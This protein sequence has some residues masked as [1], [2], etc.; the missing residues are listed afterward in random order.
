MS[1]QAPARRSRSASLPS[2]GPAPQESAGVPPGGS[3]REA[4]PA[5][6]AIGAV[7]VIAFVWVM[8]TGSYD[9]Y[10]AALVAGVLV[11][12]TIP[13]ARHA[14]KVERWPRL[15]KLVMAAMVFRI[16]GSLAR[17]FVA[18]G[19]YGGVADASTYTQVA[20][21]H[22]EAFR[23]FHLFAPTTGVFDGFVPWLDTVI[24]V[25][26]G[27]TELGA[28]FV[29]SWLNFLG[30]YLFYRAFRVGYP[31][32]DHRRYAALVLF[33]PS[34]IYWPS[35]LGKEGWMVFVIGLGCYGLARALAG[36]RF[37]Y[38]GLVAGI[39]GMLLVRPHLALIFLPAAILAFVLRRARPGR[40]RRPI[41]TVIGVVVLVV[42]LL[43]VIS[44][45]Q[46][47]FGITNLDV[48]TVT[49]QLQT[50]RVQTD[51]GNSAFNPP[52]AQ[53]PLG[54]PEAVATVLFRPFPFE[55]HGL[56]VLVA[57][58]EG[59]VLI[60]LTVL[61][62]R[63][64]AGMLRALRRNPYVLFCALYSLL[65]IFAFSNFSNFGILARERVQ[66][67][68]MYLA[69]LALP[70]PPN[71][72]AAA[73]PAMSRV[74]GKARARG[75]AE[76]ARRLRTYGPTA[77][78]GA[79]AGHYRRVVHGFAGSYQGLGYSF[80]IRIGAL[81]AEDLV[82]LI[83]TAFE[84]LAV[85]RPGEHRYVLTATGG[86]S[87]PLVRIQCDGRPVGGPVKPESVL[88]SLATDINQRAIASRP[89]RLVLHAG[90]VS[91]RGRAIILPGRS[92]AGKTTLTAAMLAVGCDYLT[93]EAVSLDL[94]TLDVEPY[95]K[96]LSLD[97]VAC[98]ALRLDVDYWA[99]HGVVPPSYLHRQKG[100]APARAAVLVFPSFEVGARSSMKRIG[101]A[102]ALV[103]LANNSFNFVDHGG[104]WLEGLA[105][106][107]KSCSAWRFTTGDAREAATM[108]F[109]SG[110]Q[111]R[112]GEAKR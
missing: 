24:Y 3:A 18:Y 103:E 72:A 76:P 23:H 9:Q 65:F 34:M 97:P 56:T 98:E 4:V 28:F 99:P 71:R 11:M 67:L 27:P 93:D 29:F 48:Q 102:E 12:A 45:A 17:Y 82:P 44:K 78:S 94:D 57:S 20:N 69:L 87:P 89:N 7:V 88:L 43:V 92:G 32:G 36:A 83:R 110:D 10:A 25:I 66:M 86:N 19:A 37:G 35:S 40:P 13:I 105:H 61:S 106:V 81:L 77:P 8:L 91:V 95:A 79:H 104:E 46:S 38:T 6:I 47:Y 5:V 75:E 2:T 1:V 64:L 107:V 90:A 16:G 111:I 112:G 62:R 109:G 96:P 54:F 15:G 49:K 14:A 26:F 53:S 52:N 55:A 31:A 73:M 60:G 74:I 41:G 84:G 21:T 59:L 30:C 51:L 42:S 85:P 100:F 63:R 33:L 68:P 80:D 58:F 70:M 22:Y 39:G 101:R 50:T 108:M